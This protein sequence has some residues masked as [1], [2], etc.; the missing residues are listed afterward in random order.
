LAQ[1]IENVTRRL[2]R[3][4]ANTTALPDPPQNSTGERDD[5]MSPLPPDHY[6]EV[7]L[8]DQLKY[9]RHEAVRLEKFLEGLQLGIIGVGVIGT[10]LAAIHLDLWVTLTTVIV[11]A[12]TTFLSY[13]RID[14]TLT[15]YNQTAID[16]ENIKGWWTALRPDE[17]VDPLNVDALVEYTERALETELSGWT[18]RMQDAL[19]ELRKAQEKGPDQLAEVQ[20]KKADD[21]EAAGA[22]RAA[23]TEGS[24]LVIA[25]RQ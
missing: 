22:G 3:T 21:K 16:L 9:F 1:E 8:D 23:P 18:Q 4:E 20:E 12:L 25:T 13:R 5:G 14:F 15:N 19:A 17:Q 10:L 2:A 6:I 11:A 24:R 7:W